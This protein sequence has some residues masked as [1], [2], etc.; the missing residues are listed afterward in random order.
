MYVQIYYNLQNNPTF[1]SEVGKLRNAVGR[2]CFVSLSTLLVCDIMGSL[3]RGL[4]DYLQVTVRPRPWPRPTV[5]RPA[6]PDPG[7]S[8][9]CSPLLFIDCKLFSIE[10]PRGDQSYQFIAALHRWQL[11]LWTSGSGFSS[12]G[13][14]SFSSS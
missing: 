11:D 12:T 3:G 7:P 8:V 14:Y 4:I 10:C 1:V 6:R 13:L 2:E 9:C 5:V